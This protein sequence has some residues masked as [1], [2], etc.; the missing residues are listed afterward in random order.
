VVADMVEPIRE[1]RA[2]PEDPDDGHLLATALEGRAAFLV[3]GD[4]HVL[5]LKEYEGVRIVTPAAFE[6]ILAEA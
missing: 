1:I 4:R 6:R 5:A 3:T 2:V